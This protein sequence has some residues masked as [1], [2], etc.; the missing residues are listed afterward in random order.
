MGVDLDEYFPPNSSA[1]VVVVDD[2]YLDGVEASLTQADKNVRKAIDQ[3]DYDKL[4]K[5]ISDS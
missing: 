2:E 4:S 5:A 1:V 3:D